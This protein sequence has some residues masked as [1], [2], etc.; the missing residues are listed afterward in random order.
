[1]PEMMIAISPHLD[2]AVL[3]CGRL[4][5]AHPGSVVITV[6]AGM[7]RDASQQ[8]DWDR[9]CGFANA[10]QAL[11][12]RREE[13]RLALAT[14]QARPRWLDFVD[15]QYGESPGSSEMSLALAAELGEL[16]N[17]PL[18]VPLGL[19]HSDHV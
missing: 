14:L 15:S 10:A 17:K 18:L 9:R 11:T 4:L 12:R 2:D 5:A 13:D 3:S 8:T 16:P 6:F 1:M 7:P 19:F